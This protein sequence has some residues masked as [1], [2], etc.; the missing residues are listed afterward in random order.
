MMMMIMMLMMMMMLSASLQII[1]S[2]GDGGSV[3]VLQLSTI[4]IIHKLLKRA[5]NVVRAWHEL[6]D[7]REDVVRT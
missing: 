7:L 5:E 3:L 2:V 4:I 6:L 1:S